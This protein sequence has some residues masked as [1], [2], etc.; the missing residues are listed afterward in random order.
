MKI[1]ELTNRYSDPREAFLD[2]NL[3]KL[4]DVLVNFIYSLSLSIVRGQPD[5]DKIPNSVL[6]KAL[7]EADLRHLAPSR[8]DRHGIGDVVE[9]IIAYY[10]LKNEVNIIEAVEILTDSMRETDFQDRNEILI[11]AKE[12]FKNLLL[13]IIDRES[14]EKN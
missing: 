2:S 9:S 13:K 1:P 11:S 4:G 5:G 6:S 7:M 3:A 12:G 8:I 14:L 10:W